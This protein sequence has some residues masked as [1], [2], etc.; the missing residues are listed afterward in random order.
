VASRAAGRVDT[1]AGVLH[2][3]TGDVHHV[4]QTRVTF[5]HDVFKLIE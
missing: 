1:I 2:A 5:R 3:A 4:S